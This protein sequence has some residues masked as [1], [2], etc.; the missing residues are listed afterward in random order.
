MSSNNKLQKDSQ[1]GQKG[2]S[3]KELVKKYESGKIPL[4][5]IMNSMLKTPPPTQSE[6]QKKG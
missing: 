6:K 1:K 4:K 5:K 3:D 2:L